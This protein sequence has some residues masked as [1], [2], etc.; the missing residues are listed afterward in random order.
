M[1]KKKRQQKQPVATPTQPPLQTFSSLFVLILFCILGVII[2]LPAFKGGFYFDDYRNFVDHSVYH[3]PFDLSALWN[4]G[5]RRFFSLWTLAWNYH[6][7]GTNPFSYHLVNLIIHIATSFVCY[8]LIALTFE[9][10]KMIHAPGR[11]Y[12]KWISLSGAL[13]FLCH[14]I[15]TQAVTYIV[16]R[17]AALAALFYISTLYFVAQASLKENKS[18]YLWAVVAAFLAIFSKENAYTLPFAIVLYYGFFFGLK[19]KPL[20]THV[21]NF[22][23]FLAPLGLVF[24]TSI[25]K[26]IA[27]RGLGSL[28][29]LQADIP[30]SE[31]ILTQFNVIRTYIRLLFV[32]I[33]QTLDYDYPI[34]KSLFEFPTFLSFLFL[35]ALVFLAFKTYK[36]YRLISF[37]I[38]FFFLTLSIEAGLVNIKDVIFEHRLYLPM[39]SFCFILPYIASLFIP[40]KKAALILGVCALSLFSVMT[41]NRNI[42]WQTPQKLW[43]DNIK[44]APNKARTNFQIGRVYLDLANQKDRD[45]RQELLQKAL[46]HMERSVE[47]DP[48]WYKAHNNLGIL[49]SRLGRFED[50]I[51][52]FER[53]VELRPTHKGA[54]NN[55][56]LTQNIL[57]KSP[58]EQQKMIQNFEFIWRD[59]SVK[60]VEEDESY[61][62]KN[63]VPTTQTTT[64]DILTQI[65][66]V[67]NTQSK[68]IT[69]DL[70]PNWEPTEKTTYELHFLLNSQKT[71]IVKPVSENG[72]LNQDSQFFILNKTSGALEKLPLLK[73]DGTLDKKVLFAL[74][75]ER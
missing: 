32:P 55:L 31:F 27:T 71:F 39:L 42:I 26:Q 72:K 8:L 73:P 22:L 20:E 48:H 12:A 64:Q 43:E 11:S 66:S 62:N 35:V 15:Q 60:G 56:R 13:L 74:K 3:N 14:P 24:I 38:A 2:Y 25:Q 49:Y 5:T 10:P 51:K 63:N 33:H 36:K 28:T 23:A 6:F 17:Q 67:L 70:G 75:A 53:T 9:T 69:K 46:Q 52:S 44:K 1:Q 41:F 16:Q 7:S 29:R 34:A 47:L 54:Q 50:A 65:A 40:N 59:T 30:H 68:L 19:K 4:H 57:K 37:S 21:F 18:Y 45:D 61:L 58:E